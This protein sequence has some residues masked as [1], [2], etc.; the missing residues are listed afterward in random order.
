MEGFINSNGTTSITLTRSTKFSDTTT[1]L[2]ETGA[3]V[4]VESDN[5]ESY[6]LYESSTGIYSAAFNLESSQKYRVHIKTSDG[7]EYVSDYTSV[8]STPPIDSITWL[9]D[10]DGVS[11]YVNAHDATG[12]TKYYLW[13]YEETW[14]FHSAYYNSVVYIRDDQ[15][16]ILGVTWKYPDHSVDTSIY[17][18]WKTLNSTSI[19]LGSTEK[20]TSDLVYLPVQYIEPNSEKLSTLYSINVK[21]YAL[22]QDEYLFLQKIKKNTEQLGTIF[23]PQ[24]SEVSGNI[25]CITN[26]NELVVGWV[27]VSQEQSK[28][29]FISNND[30]PWWNYES[31]CFSTTIDNQPDSIAKYDGGSLVPTTAAQVDAFG[32]IVKFFA[33]G[34]PTCVDCTLKGTHIKPDFW[35]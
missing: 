2:Y 28:R 13:K 11:I 14:E 18:C 30:V 31:G 9:R 24:P 5:N 4:S 1:V 35:P 27:E 29:I 10:N 17:T 6:P 34:A 22:S 3:T 19:L 12:N 33:T 8:Q 15:N 16:R 32:G 25:H 7:K 20:L 23:D 26:P 21:Q